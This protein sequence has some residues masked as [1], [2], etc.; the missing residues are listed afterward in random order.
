MTIVGVPYSLLLALLVAML[1]FVPLVG[2]VIAGI[3]VS[4]V[5]LT[6]G[7]ETAVVYAIFYFGYL[8]FEAYFIS[9][10][11]MQRAVAVPGA[12]AVIAVIAGGSLMGVIGA[13]MAIPLA[14]SAMLLIREVFMARQDRH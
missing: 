12:V 3:L 13:L 10:R 14:A 7:W 5:A 4:L 8:Q 11:V 1:A 2:A 9:P 6:V